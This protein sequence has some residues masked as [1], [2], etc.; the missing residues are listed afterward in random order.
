MTKQYGYAGRILRVDLSAGKVSHLPTE[1]YSD[2]FL[3]G[4]GIAA[5]IYWDEVS[6]R[7]DATDPENRLIFMTGPL[8]GVPGFASRFQ[9]CGKAVATNKFS[10]C[11][12][13]GSWGAQLKA[14]GYDGVI[15]QGKA[16]KPVYI[17]INGERA[18]LKEASH[19]K[20]KGGFDTEKTLRKE[21][22]ESVRVLTVGPAGENM[23][24]FATFLASD[25]SVGAGGLAG[26]MGSKN[27]KA[28]VVTG[29]NKVATA[30]PDKV[31]K[32]RSRVRE[33]HPGF[34]ESLLLTGIMTPASRF[35]KSVCQ[36]CP[37]GCVRVTYKK[38][39]GDE[40][41]FMCQAALFYETRAQRYYGDTEAAL[42]AT[43]L[44]DDYGLDTRAIETMIMW[45]S[46]C[47]HE[48]ILTEEETGIPLSKIGSYEFIETLVRKIAH[49]EGIGDLLARGTHKAAET[50]GDKA[51]KLIKDY[52]TRTGD[53]EIYGPRQYITTAIFYAVEP[54][55]PIHQ[56][57][58]I[59]VP[60]ML[61]AARAQG[62][63]EIPASSE[64]IRILGKKFWGSEIAAD[65]ST[66]EGKAL[67]AAKIQDREYAKE[68][69]IL[70]DLFWP[71]YFT[72]ATPD[73]VGDPT[74]E[75]QICA[76]VT[77]RDI[78]EQGLYKIGE[79]VLNLQRAILVR[80]GHRGREYDI[81]DEYN[82]TTPLKGD[83]GNTE[84]IVPGKDGEIFPRKGM[85][86]DRDKFEQMKSEFYRIRGWNAATGLQRKAKLE[87]LGLSDVARKLEVERLLR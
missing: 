26:V 45:L 17:S 39:D 80:E 2:L 9:V 44:C 35:K 3:G 22:G 58:E 14:A 53:N 50:L 7:I 70:C 30:S 85:V 65:F 83:F 10:Y 42:K 72:D 29:D 12:I 64:A 20:G 47:R 54:R 69:L 43:E 46:R 78:D 75:S 23:V 79:R 56:L 28:I 13:G 36:A 15:V 57:H 32:L 49:R 19:L 84:C 48:G 59:S 74:L 82:F 81:I 86:V 27:L 55:F 71:I 66:Y 4:R 33:L 73:K 77:G 51:K 41:K 37:T 76:S 60:V 52:M 16:D 87:E 63:Q 24:S 1:N 38:S 18:S 31:S 5:K 62:M 8:C 21:M 40:R 67:A 34:I 25:N 61:W 11:N 6:P 68:S